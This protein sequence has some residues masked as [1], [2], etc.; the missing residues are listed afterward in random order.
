[1]YTVRKAGREDGEAIRSILS[2]MEL[3][4]GSISIDD[5]WVGERGGEIVAVAQLQDVGG[6]QIVS[7]LGVRP[8]HRKRGVA[9]AL[10]GEMLGAA[11]E[12]VYLFTLIPGFFR[13]LGFTEA[14]PPPKIAE[15][16]TNFDCGACQ[17]ER[18]ACMVRHG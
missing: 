12:D 17:S 4:H 15:Y 5:L 14:D 13:R 3:S 8:P 18:C 16:R 7:S 10:I 6:A 2:E 1:M 11:K 9:S